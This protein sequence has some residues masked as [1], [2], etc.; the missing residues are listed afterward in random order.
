MEK[1]QESFDYKSFNLIKHGSMKELVPGVYLVLSKRGNQRIFDNKT[2]ALE[3]RS[4]RMDRRK[5]YHVGSR[6]F[7]T[8]EGIRV[9]NY[10]KGDYDDKIFQDIKKA[11]EYAIEK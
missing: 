10:Y 4:S 9:T 3:W 5:A 11:I 2:D 1:H 7:A 8:V 6:A